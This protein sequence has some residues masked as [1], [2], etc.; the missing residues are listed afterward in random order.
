[1]ALLV[2][3]NKNKNVKKLINTRKNYPF[4]ANHKY[5]Q[6]VQQ[7]SFCFVSFNI[8]MNLPIINSI[9]LNGNSKI[10]EDNTRERDVLR[11][12]T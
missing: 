7:F 1:V 2:I 3:T 10:Y 8:R 12:K 6:C 9:K 5:Q 4:L 11:F